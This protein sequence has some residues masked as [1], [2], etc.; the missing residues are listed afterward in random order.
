MERISMRMPEQLIEDI[1]E[2]ADQG[3]HANRSAVIRA[4]VRE[5]IEEREQ[6]DQ[7]IGDR[8]WAKV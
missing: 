2:T 3:H 6:D 4:A 1:D 5:Y 8:P 7:P